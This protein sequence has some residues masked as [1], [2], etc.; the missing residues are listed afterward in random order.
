MSS[1]ALTLHEKTIV[2]STIEN[3]SWKPPKS[4]RV[5]ENLQKYQILINI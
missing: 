1:K 4:E 3:H 5:I 2:I